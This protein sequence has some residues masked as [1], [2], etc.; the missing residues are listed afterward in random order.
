MTGDEVKALRVA[1]GLTSSEFASLLGTHL[2][3]VYRWESFENQ[4]ASIDP[5]RRNVLVALQHDIQAQVSANQAAELQAA[6]AKALLLGGGLFALYQLLKHI[7][8][9]RDE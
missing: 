3:S 1:L 8:R 2:S 9:D 5:L 4:P 6:V 7:F